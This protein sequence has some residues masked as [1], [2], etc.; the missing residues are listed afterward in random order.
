MA[1]ELTSAQTKELRDLLKET[2]AEGRGL[3]RSANDGYAGVVGA[4]W[5]GPA[6]LAGL[7]KNDEL[8]EH[9]NNSLQPILDELEVAILG[10]EGNMEAM[11]DEGVN[12]HNTVSPDGG[13]FGNFARLA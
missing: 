9:W 5:I 1:I 10:T 12:L 3:V 8:M 13:G 7:G 11:E 4:S 2:A 6:A